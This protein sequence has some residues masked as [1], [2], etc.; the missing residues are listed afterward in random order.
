[1]NPP[2]TSDPREFFVEVILKQAE[3]EGI[4]LTPDELEYLELARV[5]QDE[6]AERV[7]KRIVKAK[8]FDQMDERFS[9]L[10]RRSFDRE[11]AMDPVSAGRY[12]AEWRELAKVDTWPHLSMFANVLVLEN[13]LGDDR[14]G[15][16]LLVALLVLGLMILGAW[17]G[18]HLHR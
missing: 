12:Q 18:S 3:R 11:Q 10:I 7:S 6:E 4:Q 14:S 16:T 1:M 17:L 8:L 13:R 9:G 15:F 2:D 5:G